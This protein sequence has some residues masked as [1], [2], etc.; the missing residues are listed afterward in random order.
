MELIGGS[1]LV[2]GGAG[3]FGEATVRHFAALGAQVI[4]ADQAEDKGAA[5]AAELGNGSRFLKT[6]V[7]SEDSVAAAIAAA[8]ALAPLRATVVVHGGR[9][10]GARIV[11]RDGKRY[12]FET[13]RKTVDIF[14]NGTFNV[15]SQAAEAMAANDPLESDQRGVIITTASIAGFE[16]QAG[17]SDYSAAK[18]GVIGLTLVAARDLA[19]LGIRVVCIAP[20]TFFTPAYRMEEAEAQA[21]WGP[22]VP[23]P[24]RMGRT[25]E[26]ARLAGHIVENDFINGETIRID[27]A[28]RFNVK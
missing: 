13:F 7:M 4:I 27:G 26:Y 2:V 8:T 14:L 18:G 19:P 10:A 21:K 16:G 28:Q 6:D 24:K 1:A 20:G 9:A 22:M 11:G 5:L 17:Q 23:N 12:A 25:D 15:L 3:G